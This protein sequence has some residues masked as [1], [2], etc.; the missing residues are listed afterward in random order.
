MK[1]INDYLEKVFKIKP[2]GKVTLKDTDYH[3]GV[4]VLI[5]GKDT[6]IHLIWKDYAKFLEDNMINT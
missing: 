6:G 2:I 1:Y 3:I 5:D 4:K